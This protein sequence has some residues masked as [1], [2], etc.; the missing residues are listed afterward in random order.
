MNR[1]RKKKLR[2]KVLV[3]LALY[4]WAFAAM[5]VA[6]MLEVSPF[7]HHVIFHVWLGAALMIVAWPTY[8]GFRY[9][10]PQRAI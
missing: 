1:E 10:S 3:N 8:A 6:P 7:V 4:V 9:G 5:L 2:S